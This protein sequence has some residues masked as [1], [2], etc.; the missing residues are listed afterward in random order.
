MNSSFFFFWNWQQ[1]WTE[2][3]PKKICEWQISTREDAQYHS[4]FIKEMQTNTTASCHRTATRMAKMK[5]TDNIKCCQW[6]EVTQNVVYC[7]CLWECIMIQ[8]LW[9]VVWQFLIKLYI[10]FPFQLAVPVL[11]IYTRE[12]TYVTQRYM[13]EYSLQIY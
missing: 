3:S 13:C 4:L 9:K 11:C 5:K 12:V 10:N 6:C 1:L 8:P 7:W 2:T